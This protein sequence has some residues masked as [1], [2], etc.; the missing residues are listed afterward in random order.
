MCYDIFQIGMTDAKQWVSSNSCAAA[1]IARL[2]GSAGAN[3]VSSFFVCGFP[4]CIVPGSVF[5][6]AVS[7]P[8]APL[9]DHVCMLLPE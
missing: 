1:D 9:L 4:F 7:K 5:G 6:S 3:L 8:A 2:V